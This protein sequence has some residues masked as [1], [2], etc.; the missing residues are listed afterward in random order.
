MLDITISDEDIVE[1]EALENLQF[2]DC[3][4][5]ILKSLN[6]IDVQAC[7]GSGKTTLI[8]SKLIILSK[9]W[10]H[11]HQG[12]CVLS[13]TNVAKEEIIGR[14]TKSR[15][16]EANRLLSYPHFI[17]TI[18]EF[19]NK[20]LG[21]PLVRSD[22][23]TIRVIDTDTCVNL[24]YK[25][26]DFGTKRFI[27]SKSS[28]SDVLFDFNM[29]WNGTSIV[30]DIPGSPGPTT[31][32]Y[33]A[34]NEARQILCRNGYFFYKDFYVL[35]EKVTD[36][37]PFIIN[38]LQKRFPIFLLDEMQDTQ[39]FQDDLLQKIVNAPAGDVILQRFG[40]PDQAIFHG[41]NGEETNTTFNSK[42]SNDMDFVINKSH[43]F[44]HSVS[45]K[46]RGFSNSR[47]IL[48]S[49]L[50]LSDVESRRMLNTQNREFRHHIFIFDNETIEKVVPSFIEQVSTQ[51][52]AEKRK[53]PNFVVN[54]IGAV[55]NEI[56]PAKA[57]MKI[58]HYWK[59]FD[60]TK[61]ST[62]FKEGSLIEALC[63]CRRS[64]QIEWREGYKLIVSC[65]LKILQNYEKKHGEEDFSISLLKEDLKKRGRWRSF[66][67]TLFWCLKS[68]VVI[69]E[70]K[71]E[72]LIRILSLLFDVSDADKIAKPMG[73]YLSYKL[74]STVLS[75]NLYNGTSGT[76]SSIDGDT[77][78]SADGLKIQLSTIHAVKGET[79]DATLVL[80]T[81][82]Y[83]H[84]LQVLMPYL[85]NT[86]S[87]SPTGERN[88][89]FMRQL[90]VGMSRP[91]HLLCLAIHKDHITSE[92]QAKLTALGWILSVV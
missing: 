18:Q 41:I 55:G 50:S 25:K 43:R 36:E 63:H 29:S 73:D 62:S 78:Q 13:H 8:A 64:A 85:T 74:D 71:W 28:H 1:M 65:I 6:S 4:K 10:K 32:S 81:K 30:F 82:N 58:G 59:H 11:R 53:D 61:G 69:T 88:K 33:K 52:T 75:Q 80:E 87:D 90:Y 27:D 46:I 84:D 48:E 20:F 14:L 91:K 66:Q 86:A 39:K 38:I 12:L 40:D 77:I 47:I 23:T 57:Q 26:L 67:K 42:P 49:E 22:G 45:S 9:K 76:V 70:K 60:K 16:K 72:Q 3:R 68:D 17:G 56:D 37:N 24:I 44:N 92:E 31:N 2:D 79:H 89:K 15:C 34:L 19:I 5:A 21:A 51:F 83:S 54:I 7:P 35:A